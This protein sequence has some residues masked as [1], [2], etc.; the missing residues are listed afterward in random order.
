MEKVSVAI[1]IFDGVHAGHQQILAEAALH[2]KVVALTFYPHPTSVFAPERTPTSLVNLEDRISL[3]EEKGFPKF[4]YDDNN[5]EINYDYL[6]R[7]PIISLTEEKITELENQMS[8]KSA[9]L[10]NIKNKTEKDIWMDDL[11]AISKLL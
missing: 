5:K 3:L 6:T 9:Q 2:G 1:G 8:K 10:E 11:D 4:N 7:M